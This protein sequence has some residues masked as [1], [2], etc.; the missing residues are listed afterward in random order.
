MMPLSLLLALNFAQADSVNPPLVKFIVEVNARSTK[1]LEP[2]KLRALPKLPVTMPVPVAVPGWPLPL[3]SAAVEPEASSKCQRPAVPPAPPPS[4]LL[5]PGSVN[6]AGGKATK[7][8]SA[9]AK[10]GR[11]AWEIEGL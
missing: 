11:D 1:S 4:A 7:V 3:E 8:P 2:L 6:V 5:K 10:S 9:V